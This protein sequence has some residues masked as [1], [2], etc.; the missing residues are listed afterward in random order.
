MT[1][2]ADRRAALVTG[3]NRGIGRSIVEALARQ[4]L[5][6]V[7]T[8]R[9]DAEEAQAVV[10]AIGAEGGTAVALHLD[11]EDLDSL[12]PFAEELTR[13]LRGR[14][15]R[16]QLD[17]LVNN[18]GVGP[19]A[20]AAATSEEQFDEMFMVNV[21][22]VFFLTQRLLDVIADGGQIINLSSGLTR[23]VA[24]G[25]VA[26]AMTKGAIE[27]FTRHLAAELGPRRI[28]VNTFAPGPVTTG[29]GGGYIRDDGE[30]RARLG[31]LAALGGVADADDI[32]PAIAALALPANAFI[33]AERIEASGGFKL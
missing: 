7:F 32:G 33:N 5:A 24:P 3:G 30:V 28:R 29:F 27:V 1:D 13:V 17:V 9:S 6:V 16:E 4:G 18:A 25:R 2:R 19:V 12:D 15:G 21:K 11:L 26:Y 14:L 20:T 10:D 22:G 8:Y 23:F 31:S